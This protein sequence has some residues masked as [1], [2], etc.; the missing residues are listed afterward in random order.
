MTTR[1]LPIPKARHSTYSSSWRGSSPRFPSLGNRGVHYFGAYSSKARAYR[2]KR[3]FTLTSLGTTHTLAS[4]D[5]PKLSPKKRAALRKSW[6]QLIRRVYLVDPLKCDCGGTYRVIA[7]I[8]EPKIIGKILRHLRN[9]KDTSRAPP[10]QQP[11]PAFA[12]S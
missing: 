8:T 4:Q 5:E 6:A 1:C 9:R 12:S 11:E 2:K 7:F 10:T 3:S